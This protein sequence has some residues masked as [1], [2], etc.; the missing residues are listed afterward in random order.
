LNE[1][2]TAKP[3]RLLRP[4]GDGLP[5]TA[6]CQACNGAGI[7]R[8]FHLTWQTRTGEEVVH[9]AYQMVSESLDQV[10]RMLVYEGNAFASTGTT[11]ED[12]LSI[13]RVDPMREDA[14]GEFL[15]RTSADWSLVRELTSDESL[16]ATE[17]QGQHY[18]TRRLHRH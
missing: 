4:I 3:Q 12:L 5:D 14:V 18:Y 8:H 7:G 17:Y 9:R 15:A 6:F 2:D 1:V 10:E 13:T 11:E 16:V